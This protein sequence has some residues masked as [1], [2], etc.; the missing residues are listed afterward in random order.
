MKTWKF[1]PEL[2]GDDDVLARYSV[3]PPN[4]YGFGHQAYYEH[5][6]DCIA[7]R[8]SQPGRRPRGP[9]QPRADLG[10]LRVDRDRARGAPAVHAE[11]CAGSASAVIALAAEQGMS[12]TPQFS[13]A[14]IVDV[15]F[16][17]GRAGRAAG[18]PLRVPHRGRCFIG[19]F[20]EIQRGVVVGRGTRVQS[21][22]FICELVTIGD[23]LLHRPRR[24]VH[25][26]HVCDGRPSARRSQPVAVH[27]RRQQRLDRLQCDDPARA[28]RGRRR[29]RRGRGRDA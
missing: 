29:D 21:H 6:V 19:P 5:V 9:A 28:D 3:N 12:G 4:V 14:D 25:Q 16:G 10:D 18:Q 2:P 8:P 15:E 7:Q 26:R 1:E 23:G 17:D 13:D 20:V 22:A 27:D 24:Q 11:A